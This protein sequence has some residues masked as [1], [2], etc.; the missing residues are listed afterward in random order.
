[1]WI[2]LVKTNSGRLNAYTINTP[3]R[4]AAEGLVTE[5]VQKKEFAEC[6]TVVHHLEFELLK[7]QSPEI[8]PMA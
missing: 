4:D 3:N 6:L 7:L 1:M 2:A 5:A 8:L